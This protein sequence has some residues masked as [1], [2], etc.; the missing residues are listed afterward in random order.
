[1]IF[2]N[3]YALFSWVNNPHISINLLKHAIEKLDIFCIKHKINSQNEEWIFSDY[4]WYDAIKLINS[5]PILSLMY[6]ELTDPD[7]FLFIFYPRLIDAENI[8]IDL[9]VHFDITYRWLKHQANSLVPYLKEHNEFFLNIMDT[10]YCQELATCLTHFPT[11]SNAIKTQLTQYSV[12]LPILKDCL[13]KE[14]GNL[15]EQSIA[16]LDAQLK[17]T[18]T[19]RDFLCEDILFWIAKTGSSVTDKQLQPLTVFDLYDLFRIVSYFSSCGLLNAT[20]IDVMIA[21]QTHKVVVGLWQVLC[22]CL[23]AAKIQLSVEQRD[24]LL[25]WMKQNQP[26]LIDGMKGGNTCRFLNNR[27]VNRLLTLCEKVMALDSHRLLTTATFNA[28]WSV[29]TVNI[30]KPALVQVKKLSRKEH[31]DLKQS[32]FCI[33]EHDFQ[34]HHQKGY[35]TLSNYPSTSTVD[36]PYYHDFGTCGKIKK[37]MLGNVLYRL[38]KF[39]NVK[40][41]QLAFF[42]MKYLKWLYEGLYYL[43]QHKHQTYFISPWIEG[44]ALEDIDSDIL[45]KYAVQDKIQSLYSFFSALNRLHE[46]GRV[47]GDVKP[48]NTIFN[49]YTMTLTLID[50]DSVHQP[51]SRR[52][53]LYNLYRQNGLF[54]DDSLIDIY[55]AGSIVMCLFPE[56]Y[57]IKS[58][59]S[60]EYQLIEGNSLDKTLIVMLVDACMHK[61]RSI[62]STAKDI[63]L[64][65]EALRNQS[66]KLTEE[67]LIMLQKTYLLRET[68]TVDDVIRGAKSPYLTLN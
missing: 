62:R 44:Q 16:L 10:V 22:E 54:R 59:N 65:I 14:K 25:D 19:E 56:F 61:K 33:G 64:F 26:V 8:D 11:P 50:F 42:E 23:S 29:V 31:P 51:Y 63:M 39:S 55:A 34:L 27:V 6:F 35:V 36:S 7:R 18:P 49:G 68:I 28:I 46:I 60:I 38:K 53:C 48:T 1:M 67:A 21:Y 32:M 30:P 20:L 40:T 3:F 41:A 17:K 9:P 13:I 15:S 4:Q 57:A 12:I 24:T 52:A 5:T 2:K 58:K 45:K 47:H 37:V 66:E 43:F